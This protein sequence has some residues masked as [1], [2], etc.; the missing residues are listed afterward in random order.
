MCPPS[1]LCCVRKK[2]QILSCVCLVRSS[3]VLAA[4][5][6]SE[7]LFYG[8]FFEVQ[9][10]LWT[11]GYDEERVEWGPRLL[12]PLVPAASGGHLGAGRGILDGGLTRRQQAPPPGGGEE[13]L[14]GQQPSSQDHWLLLYTRR[15]RRS[16][17]RILQQ[18]PLVPPSAPSMVPWRTFCCLQHI[19]VWPV[20]PVSNWCPSGAGQTPPIRVCWFGF[21]LLLLALFCSQWIALCEFSQ[22][23]LLE[24]Y[25]YL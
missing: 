5:A 18:A 10:N 25:F 15:R 24:I 7:W 1:R 6:T 21:P 2:Y 14:E 12:S 23:M 9:S 22:K 13:A 11:N 19:P 8:R 3:R 17:S 16:S 20:W 4:W